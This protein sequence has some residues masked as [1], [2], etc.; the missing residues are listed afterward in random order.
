[1]GNHHVNVV[2]QQMPVF[3]AAI[4]LLGQLTKHLAQVLAQVSIQH[5]PAAFGN[6]NNVVLALPLRVA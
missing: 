1:M 3:N 2:G 5:L 6:E 4:L